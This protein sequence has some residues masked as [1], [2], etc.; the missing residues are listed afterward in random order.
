L[1]IAGLFQGYSKAIPV[2]NPL[3]TQGE[4]GLNT[5]RIQTEENW[6]CRGKDPAER[7]SKKGIAKYTEPQKV[8]QFWGSILTPTPFFTI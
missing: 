3:R 4:H 5:E 7:K 2:A 1:A 6:M 8:R